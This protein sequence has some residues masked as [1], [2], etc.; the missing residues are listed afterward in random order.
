M[1][2][3]AVLNGDTLEFQKTKPENLLYI[4]FSEEDCWGSLLYKFKGMVKNVRFL[5]KTSPVNVAGAFYGFSSLEHFDKTNLDLSRATSLKRMFGFCS[6]L[7]TIDLSGLNISGVKDLSELFAGCKNLSEINLSGWDTSNTED[8][9]YMFAYCYSLSSL[10]LSSFSM[11][12]VKDLSNLCC[13]SANLRSVTF[14]KFPNRNF[15]VQSMLEGC[16]SLQ[17]VNISNLGYLDD[18]RAERLLKGCKTLSDIRASA[19]NLMFL[20]WMKGV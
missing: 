15:L 3:Y 7:E 14:P 20:K 5:D 10:D 17:E 13:Y 19:E 12:S 2:Y 18:Y 11:Q 1:Q 16:T 6:A 8:F 4:A 9:Q